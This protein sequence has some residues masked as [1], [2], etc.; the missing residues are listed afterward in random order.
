VILPL[1]LPGVCSGALLAFATSLD[2]V[3]T[4]IFLAGPDQFTLPRQ[5]LVGIRDYINPTITAVAT[6]LIVISILLLTTI[7][8]FRRRTERITARPMPDDEEPA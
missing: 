6:V 8:I 7:E 3:V 5:M 4:V 1:A 2:E